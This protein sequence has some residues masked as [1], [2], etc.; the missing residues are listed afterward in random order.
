ML[1]RID[2]LRGRPFRGTAGTLP[3]EEARLAGLREPRLACQLGKGSGE[4][5]GGK[6]GEPYTWKL[7]RD[8]EVGLGL[9]KAVDECD[10]LRNAAGLAVLRGQPTTARCSSRRARRLAQRKFNRGDGSDLRGHATVGSRVWRVCR[11]EQADRCR[12]SRYQCMSRALRCGMHQ[13][14]GG[15]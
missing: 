14:R 3:A 13:D 10:D 1:N 9:T 4:A 12:R 8:A 6:A 5:E 15:T 7:R 2:W 11:W